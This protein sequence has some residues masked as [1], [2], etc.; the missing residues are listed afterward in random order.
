MLA[1]VG[2]DGFK[3]ALGRLA[4]ELKSCPR[5]D[6]LFFDTRD[7]EVSLRYQLTLVITITSVVLHAVVT[8]K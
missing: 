3:P 7:A 1:G 5:A 4:M 8:I 6:L 2:R